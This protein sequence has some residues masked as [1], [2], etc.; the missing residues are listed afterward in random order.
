MG[1][2]D[3]VDRPDS[4]TT[5]VDPTVLR[6][7]DTV[8]V[9]TADRPLATTKDVDPMVLRPRNT[10]NVDSTAHLPVDT[11]KEDP[12]GDTVRPRGNVAPVAVAD[13]F[14]RWTKMA[15]VPSRRKS[16]SVFGI[17]AELTLPRASASDKL[18]LWTRLTA[19]EQR[20]QYL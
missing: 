8:N 12:R 14:K 4:T 7:I 2:V 17:S 1:S 16:S 9:D 15:M 13:R 10:G 5:D 20:V 6:R 18:S 11:M 19:R 3:T